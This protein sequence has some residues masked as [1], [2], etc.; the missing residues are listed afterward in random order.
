MD[1]V[2]ELHQSKRQ[3]ADDGEVRWG[4]WPLAAVVVDCV[5]VAVAESDECR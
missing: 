4:S 5:A 3:T 2:D 1:G